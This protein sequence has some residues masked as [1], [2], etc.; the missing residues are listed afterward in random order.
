MFR[1]VRNILGGI[2]LAIGLLGAT[3]AMAQ[4]AQEIAGKIQ[5]GMWVD[6]DGC[7]HWWA[8]GG[9]EG[10]MLD[11]VNPKTG[12]PV[13]LK[14]NTCMVANTD[15]LFATDS[16]KLTAHGRKY[17]QDFFNPP[18]PLAMPFTA[19]PT[20]A[21]W[22]NTTSACR[23]VAPRPWPMSAARSGPWLSE[24][25]AMASASR[26]PP[27]PRRQGC[28]R[29]V[30]LKSCATGGENDEQNFPSRG[31]AAWR[32]PAVWLRGWL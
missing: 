21:L 19:I 26:L 22:M 4:T 32:H 31:I 13:C 18:G 15:T 25:L 5:W 29:I 28:R 14:V 8:D 7:M 10:Y 17:L 9:L 16:A 30:V 3:G 12:K 1:A 23:S 2:A 27:I 20:A 6:D 24:K 11:R